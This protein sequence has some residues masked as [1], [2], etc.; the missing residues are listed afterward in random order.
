MV[1]K[2]LGILNQTLVLISV[3]GCSLI[4]QHT[5]I[6]KA[7]SEVIKAQPDV[8]YLHLGEGSLLDEE[9][10]WRRV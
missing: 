2:G 4:K 6:I 8:L 5:E 1:R 3:G 7:L 10:N 9:V